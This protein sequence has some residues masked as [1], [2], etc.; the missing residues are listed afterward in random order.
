MSSK[1]VLIVENWNILMYG[2]NAGTPIAIPIYTVLPYCVITMTMLVGSQDSVPSL[3]FVSSMIS[4]ICKSNQ[5]KTEKN[6]F[7]NGSFQSIN[8]Y[9]F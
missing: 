7:E 6:N 1:D 5:N 2:Y 8:L 3:M 4:E 9:N